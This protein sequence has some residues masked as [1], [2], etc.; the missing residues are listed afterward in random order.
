LENISCV[1]NKIR[2]V[3]TLATVCFKVEG[4]KHEWEA[5]V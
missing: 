5:V 3:G 2:N 1:K 4:K